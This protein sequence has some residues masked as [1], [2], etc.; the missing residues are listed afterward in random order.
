MASDEQIAILFTSD[1]AQDTSC[2]LV[3]IFKEDS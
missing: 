3:D 1:Q 2:A